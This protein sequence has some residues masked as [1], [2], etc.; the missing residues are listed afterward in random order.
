MDTGTFYVTE[1]DRGVTEAG[2]SS[3]SFWYA[4]YVKSRHEFRVHE[5]LTKAHIETFL[6]TVE[7]LRRWKDRKKLVT[8]PLFPG[9]LFVYIQKSKDDILSV[10]KTH[11]VVRFVSAEPGKPSAVPEVQIE[12]LKKLVDSKIPLEPYPYLKE[13]QRVRIKSGSLAG[14]EGILEKR[15]GQHMLVL[16]VDILRQG[17]SLKIEAFDVEPV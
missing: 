3:K 14:V 8:F 7:M 9:Y 6:P 15:K 12:S 1:C 5:L 2:I 10:L 13:G 4:V 17:A 11:G 16:S